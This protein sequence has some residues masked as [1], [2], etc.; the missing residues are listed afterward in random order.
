MIRALSKRDVKIRATGEV[1]P[2][3]TQVKIKFIKHGTHSVDAMLII[4][5]D[6]REIKSSSWGAFF[7]EPSIKTLEKWS[8][9]CVAKSVTGKR[10]EPDG[11]GIDGSP[12][13]LIALGYI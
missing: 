1:V 9:D 7:T 8:A 5:P 11:Y 10:T 4:L 12:S 3:G 13:W 6:G 2:A